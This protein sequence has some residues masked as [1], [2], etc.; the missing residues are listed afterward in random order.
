MPFL[1]EAMSNTG[2]AIL[3]VFAECVVLATLRGRYMNLRSASPSNTI[4]F[5]TKLQDIK[6]CLQKRIQTIA[7]HL[8]VTTAA[9]NSTLGFTHILA[10]S[11]MINLNELAEGMAFAMN[12]HQ[13]SVT[14]CLGQAFDA[15]NEIVRLAKS[16]A[17]LGRFKVFSRSLDRN[18]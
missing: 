4:D 13:K 1:S 15:C 7:K 14:I 6:V 3:P 12:E 17:R 18:I 10:Y 8:P 2:T 9:A 5:C 16:S 11:V